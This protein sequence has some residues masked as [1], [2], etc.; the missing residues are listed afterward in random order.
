MYHL[1][2]LKYSEF[3]VEKRLRLKF[4]CAKWESRKSGELSKH[5]WSCWFGLNAKFLERTALKGENRVNILKEYISKH[6]EKRRNE[7]S[8]VSKSKWGDKIRENIKIGRI[9]EEGIN[10]VW[11]KMNIKINFD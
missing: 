10:A 2:L 5:S 9:H 6:F 1:S 11:N 4:H 8:Y 3:N 7:E